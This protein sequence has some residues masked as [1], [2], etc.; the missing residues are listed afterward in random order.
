MIQ[1]NENILAA[2]LPIDEGSPFRQH[3]L[4]RPE[5]C[6]EG[7]QCLSPTRAPWLWAADHKQPPTFYKISEGIP[8]TRPVAES[9]TRGNSI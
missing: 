8:S 1:D 7:L 3:G 9:N 4:Q 5:G 2:E 6:N